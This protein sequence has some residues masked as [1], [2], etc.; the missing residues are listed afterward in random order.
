MIN[1]QPKT[2]PLTYT[3]ISNKTDGEKT[4][5]DRRVPPL[6][7]RINSQDDTESSSPIFGTDFKSLIKPIRIKNTP[8]ENTIFTSSNAVWK[9][10]N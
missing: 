8:V 1:A 9:Y 7:C 10:P 3:S 4:T 5:K 2:K 6:K